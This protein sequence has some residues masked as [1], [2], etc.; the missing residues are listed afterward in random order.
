MKP[1]TSTSRIQRTGGKFQPY[2]K[3]KKKTL[4]VCTCCLDLV[5]LSFCRL[6][7]ICVKFDWSTAMSFMMAM[8][9]QEC[10]QRHGCSWRTCHRHSCCSYTCR[11][12]RKLETFFW[13]RRRGCY[14]LA[15]ASGLSCLQV[16]SFLLPP[17]IC[18][19][20]YMSTKFVVGTGWA[21]F[22]Q[23]SQPFPVSWLPGTQF[24]RFR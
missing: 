11:R 19:I 2:K 3:E 16:W 20:T 1:S 14:F 23:K 21:Y 5:I 15:E 10:H 22:H 18:Y 13:N 7:F 6:V 4:R 12:S 24:Q 17:N 9:M 8:S